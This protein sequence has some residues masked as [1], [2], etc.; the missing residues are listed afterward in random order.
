MENELRP[1][2]TRIF[3]FNWKFGVFLLLIVCI[4]RFILTMNANETGDYSS[5]GLIMVI[6]ALIPFIFLTKSGRNAIGITKPKKHG[7]LFMAFIAGLIFSFLFYY[8]GQNLYGNSYSN[9]YSYIGK[10]YDIP[11]EINPNEK[12]ILFAIVAL[13]GMVFSPIGEEFFFRGIVQSAF[14]ESI[15]EKKSSIVGSSAFAI[16]HLA[17]FGLV[18]INDHWNYLTIPSLIWVAG[19]FIVSMVFLVFKKYSGS[20]FGASICHSAFNLAMIYCIFYMM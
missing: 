7:W 16:T 9:W 12:A 17:H 6:S 1:V 5:I 19:L 18:Y 13:T 11:A 15:A 3:N 10:S 14:S 2:W 8:L 20:V 4:P